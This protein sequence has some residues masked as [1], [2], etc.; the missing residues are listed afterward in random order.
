MTV[1]LDGVTYRVG[2]RWF[3][4]GEWH[5][6]P[7]PGREGRDFSRYRVFVPGDYERTGSFRIHRLGPGDPAE[8]DGGELA[9]QLRGS[10]FATR[11]KFDPSTRDPGPRPT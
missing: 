1:T 9:R 2:V 11:E 5:K 7:P 3:A 10:T 4:A 6:R 8:V